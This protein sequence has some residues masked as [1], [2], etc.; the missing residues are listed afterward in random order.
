MS[1]TLNLSATQVEIL[2]RDTVTSPPSLHFAQFL[3]IS[4]PVVVESIMAA[5]PPAV[6]TTLFVLALFS[7]YLT[8]GTLVT[9][10]IS[11][12]IFF[13][14][15]ICLAGATFHP[16]PVIAAAS[17][18]ISII[19][20]CFQSIDHIVSVTEFIKRRMGLI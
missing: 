1:M 7:A 3:D 14:L 11:P 8:T 5:P 18:A 9:D 12:S 16:T 19:A 4:L 13:T 20:Q 10:R 15:S 2:I 17:L 6:L